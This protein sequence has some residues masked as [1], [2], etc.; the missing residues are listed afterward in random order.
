MKCPFAPT[1]GI[2]VCEVTNLVPKSKGAIAIP[3]GKTSPFMRVVAVG[4]GLFN[5]TGVEI[6]ANFKSGDIVLIG[7][8]NATDV[9]FPDLDNP[10]KVIG[11][12]VLYVGA[13]LAKVDEGALTEASNVVLG[14]A[15]N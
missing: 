4:P 1:R 15:V 14:A 11:Y 9:A 3:K 6:K 2:I 8:S 12:S 10:G 7:D 13:A 5:E